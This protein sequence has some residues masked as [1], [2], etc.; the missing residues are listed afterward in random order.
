MKYY[1]LFI[2]ISLILL[3]NCNE[4]T[5]PDNNNNDVDTT[6]NLNYYIYY[7]L[8]QSDGWRPEHSGLFRYSF[9]DSGVP[10]RILTESI[11][12][13]SMVGM[14]GSIIIEYEYLPQKFHLRYCDGT[15]VPLQFPESSQ[16]GWE[17]SWSV[18]P[19]IELSGD[20]SKAVFFLTFQKSDD[21]HKE[22]NQLKLI[23]LNLSESTYNIFDLTQYCINNFYNS[24][25]NY[26]EAYG[27][28]ILVNNNADKIVFVTKLFTFEDESYNHKGYSIIEL[29]DNA[30]HSVTGIIEDEIDLAGMDYTGNIYAYFNGI[31]NSINSTGKVTPSNLSKGIISPQQFSMVKSEI[32][33]WSDEGISLYNTLTEQKLSDI[34]T[35]DSIEVL[36]PEVNLKETKLLSIAPDGGLITFGLEVTQEPPAYN[37]YAI[38]PNDRIMKTLLVNTPIGRPVISY[39]LE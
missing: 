27:D 26:A 33:V 18:P 34:I 23:V 31:L 2:T 20:G 19:H 11:V 30:F 16:T 32:V 28:N 15:V 12:H 38:R 1:Y 25:I 10:E 6:Q 29:N 5:K 21:I 13:T 24:E 35:W 3:M 14:N 9:N 8:S 36:Y 37:L 22:E 39:G 7:P 17:Y 4:A